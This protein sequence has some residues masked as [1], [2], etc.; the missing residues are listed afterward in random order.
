MKNE[1]IYKF[2]KIKKESS[3]EEIKFAYRKKAKENHPD[4]GGERRD[5]E[6]ANKYYKI[7]INS[8]ARQIYDKTG[9]IDQNKVDLNEHLSILMKIF[10]EVICDIR[11]YKTENVFNKMHKIIILKISECE[12]KIKICKDSND[13]IKEIIKRIKCKNGKNVFLILLEEKLNINKQALIELNKKIEI[14]NKSK[15]FLKNFNYK[16][17]SRME[18]AFE[19]SFLSGTIE[20]TR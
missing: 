5:F 9:K 10:E 17:D 15:K 18:S 11:D 19:F 13:N 1:D 12:K 6:K 14:F 8:E 7:L 20:D 4:L 3:L 2:F 16:T